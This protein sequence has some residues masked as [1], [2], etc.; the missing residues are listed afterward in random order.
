MYLK[1]VLNILCIVAQTLGFSYAHRPK[2]ST[3]TFK[4]NMEKD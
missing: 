2:A 3:F 4:K 1:D